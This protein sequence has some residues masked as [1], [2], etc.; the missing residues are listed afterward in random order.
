MSGIASIAAR[1][2][3][4]IGS[5]LDRVALNPQPLPPREVAA[6]ALQRL[7]DYCGTVP[8]RFPVPPP[9][10]FGGGVLAL[11]PQLDDLGGGAL[12]LR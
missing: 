10:P 12:R 3:P 2:L 1:A 6:A 5:L 7:D 4:S 11:H 9:P 8:K